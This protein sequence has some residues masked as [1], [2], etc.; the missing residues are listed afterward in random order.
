MSPHHSR[1]FALVSAV[2]VL[3]FFAYVFI[4]MQRERQHEP[5]ES[6]AVLP[7]AT[8]T[9]PAEQKAE[10]APNIAWKFV[11]DGFVGNDSALAPLSVLSVSLNNEPSFEVGRLTGTCAELT[12][13]QLPTDE[14]SGVLCWWAGGGDEVGVFKESDGRYVLKQGSQSEGDAESAGFRGDFSIIK[15]FS[16][17]AEV[18]Q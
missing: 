14:I 2:V 12:P 11:P 3:L 5:A 6:P 4:G 9:P 18:A 10:I 16:Y 8:T 15:S 17:P 13:D 1:S 7:I